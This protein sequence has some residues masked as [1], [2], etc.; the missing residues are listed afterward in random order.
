MSPVQG[1][2]LSNHEQKGQRRLNIYK[3]KKK[4]KKKEREKVFQVW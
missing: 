3:K 2:W 1:K 4:K